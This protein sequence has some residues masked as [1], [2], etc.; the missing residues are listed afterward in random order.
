MEKWED[1]HFKFKFLPTIQQYTENMSLIESVNIAEIISDMPFTLFG[2][3][4]DIYYNN[5]VAFF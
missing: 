4:K 2:A 1:E 5:P 3:E